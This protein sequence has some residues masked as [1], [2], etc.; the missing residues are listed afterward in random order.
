MRLFRHVGALLGRAD[1]ALSSF[2]APA[3]ERRDTP[4]LWDVRSA[5]RVIVELLPRH[6]DNT[7][8]RAAHLPPTAF[9][10][11]MLAKYLA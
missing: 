7:P 10:A 1:N 2:S 8:R 5:A 11:H 6:T 3:L 9:L 4:G